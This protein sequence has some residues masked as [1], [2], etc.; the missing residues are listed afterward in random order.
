LIRRDQDRSRLRNV[1]LEGAA[2]T[3]GKPMDD[4]YFDALR[5]RVQARGAK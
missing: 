4:R 3:P 1:L 2:S 5:H